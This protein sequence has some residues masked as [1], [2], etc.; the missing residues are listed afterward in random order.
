MTRLSPSCVSKRSI[1]LVSVYRAHDTVRSVVRDWVLSQTDV[2]HPPDGATEVLATMAASSPR[3]AP[4]KGQLKGS[5]VS[6]QI[7]SFNTKLKAKLKT[8]LEAKCNTSLRHF[9]PS[10]PWTHTVA[11][12]KSAVVNRSQLPARRLT[13][14][15]GAPTG[16]ARGLITR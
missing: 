12:C 1:Y 7:P 5:W 13:G 9:V 16:A 8:R 11:M 4:P 14:L 15:H 10:W 6:H 2:L 3:P